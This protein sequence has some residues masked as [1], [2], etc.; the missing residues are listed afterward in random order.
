MDRLDDIYNF[1]AISIKKLISIDSLDIM[2]YFSLEEEWKDKIRLKFYEK[3]SFLFNKN[4]AISH[5]LFGYDINVLYDVF[6]ELLK[7]EEYD[8]AI[9]FLF[10]IDSNLEYNNDFFDE[11]EFESLNSNYQDTQIR[12]LPNVK[13]FWKRNSRGK[14]HRLTL[15]HVFQNFYYI[16]N[17]KLIE[18]KIINIILD[19]DVFY[20]ALNNHR[21]RIGCSPLTDKKTICNIQKKIKNHH[22]YFYIDGIENQQVIN[23]K[24]IKTLELAKNHEVDILVFPEM[25]GSHFINSN[26]ER[27][28]ANDSS[29]NS[30]P[31]LIVLP[32]IYEYEKNTAEV[33]ID[34][35]TMY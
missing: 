1:L 20:Q 11:H 24:V 4:K 32:S 19:A 31:P 15:N 6:N 8:E 10:I 34:E 14:Q 28:L 18:F 17:E 9:Y 30:Y 23:E 27:I 35:G 16:Y 21:L 13:C 33:F 5:R 12:I 3:A 22:Q 26:V 29:Y 25:L 7:N 2:L